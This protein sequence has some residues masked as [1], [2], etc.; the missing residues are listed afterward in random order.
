[1]TFV[2]GALISSGRFA[3]SAAILGAFFFFSPDPPDFTRMRYV[4]YAE[5]QSETLGCIKR[6]ALPTDALVFVG[7]LQF[8][9][10]QTHEF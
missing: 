8:R 1:M 4:G 6:T 2:T 10:L 3:A 9:A 5:M 7:L